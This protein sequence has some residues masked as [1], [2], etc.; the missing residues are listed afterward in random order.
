M[1]TFRLSFPVPQQP[2]TIQL[3][4]LILLSGSCFTEHIGNLLQ[5]SG[6]NVLQN[7][8]GI[9][10]NPVSITNVLISYINA[11]R[12]TEKDIFQQQDV[13]HSWNHHSRV[14]ATSA[15]QLLHNLNGAQDAAHN[16][17]KKARWLVITLGSAYVYRNKESQQVVANCH[18]LP[19]SQF[20][21]ELLTT[22]TIL[23]ALDTLI[24]RLSFFNPDIKVIFSISPVRHIRDG[25]VENNKSK[26][27]L[28]QA[29]HHIVEKFSNMYYFPAYEI[30]IDELRDYRFYTN[31]LV[32]PNDTAIQYI[33]QR[34]TEAAIH[35]AAVPIMEEVR[36]LRQAAAHRPQFTNTTQ[37]TV[38]LEKNHQKA[39][40]LHQQHPYLELNDLLRYFSGNQ[41]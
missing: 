12:Y 30:L 2:D 37:H 20:N 14:S 34:F 29:V 5:S 10:F 21:K 28:I 31:D 8:N 32:H 36:K 19:A 9:L 22:E 15:A 3:T 6:F 35:P 7:P 41:P 24:Y 23:A 1:E 16:F 17:L 40:Q 39:K 11:T 38:F 26:A 18:K 25:I 27:A 13:W 4:D 33:W